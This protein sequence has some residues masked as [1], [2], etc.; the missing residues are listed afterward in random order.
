MGKKQHSKKKEGFADTKEYPHRKHP[1]RYRKTSKD[2]SIIYL[3]TTH[4]DEVEINGKIVKT[5]PLDNNI[6]PSERNQPD[7][8]SYIYPKVYVGKRSHL[9]KERLDL[10]LIGDDIKRV[11]ELFDTLPR[12]NVKY[13]TN[14]KKKK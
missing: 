3:T 6:N 4:H 1:A 11:D 13:Q 10:W 14:S 12:E 9:G 2:D 7:K 5:I 8:K